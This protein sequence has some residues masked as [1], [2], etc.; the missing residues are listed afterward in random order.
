MSIYI[1]FLFDWQWCWLMLISSDWCWCW[2]LLI[3]VILFKVGG[4]LPPK[5]GDSLLVQSPV[6]AQIFLSHNGQCC[7]NFQHK[8]TRAQSLKLEISLHLKRMQIQ[9]ER[10]FK[11]KTQY[12]WF[13]RASGN[14]LKSDL[15]FIWICIFWLVANWFKIWPSGDVTCISSKVGT[16]LCHLHCHF[17]LECP[18]GIIIIR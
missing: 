14:I 17:V 7:Y 8:I 16:R 12:P 1:D 6:Y 2:L 5:E 13:P 9:S 3:D 15:Y 11:L 18:I 4:M 10:K